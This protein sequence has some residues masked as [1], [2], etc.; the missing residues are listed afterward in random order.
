MGQGLRRMRRTFGETLISIGALGALITTMVLVDDRV[1]EQMAL[2][3]GGTSVSA[4]LHSATSH[5]RNVGDIVMM[6]ARDRGLEHGPV[7]LFGI[8]AVVLVV[9]MLTLR[10]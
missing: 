4:E 7:L 8:A 5:A 6:A 10:N 2:R 1:R 3:F 9:L